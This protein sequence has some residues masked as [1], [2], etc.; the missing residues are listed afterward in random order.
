[1]T[2]RAVPSLRECLWVS[3]VVCLFSCVYAPVLSAQSSPQTSLATPQAPSQSLAFAFSTISPSFVSPSVVS[4]IVAAPAVSSTSRSK[5]MVAVEQRFVL[6]DGLS[7]TRATA[8]E[9]APRKKR[10]RLS[11]G[12]AAQRPTGIGVGLGFGPSGSTFSGGTFQSGAIQSGVSGSFGQIRGD[13]G[14]RFAAAD[15]QASALVGDASAGSRVDLDLQWDV[16]RRWT[17]KATA[18]GAVALPDS[19]Q[20]TAS[21][22][23]SSFAAPAD[24]ERSSRAPALGSALDLELAGRLSGFDVRASFSDVS[25]QYRDPTL[26]RQRATGQQSQLQVRRKAQF[27]RVDALVQSGRTTTKRGRAQPE[28]IVT[29]VNT[30]LRLPLEIDTEVGY[31]ELRT[32]GRRESE[33]RLGLGRQFGK[34]RLGWRVRH[35]EKEPASAAPVNQQAERGLELRY[36]PNPSLVVTGGSKE[37]THTA[38]PSDRSLRSLYF[39]PVWKLADDA[40]VVKL[41]FDWSVEGRSGPGRGSTATSEI[42][43]QSARGTLVWKGLSASDS[44]G[45]VAPDMPSL[46]ERLGARLDLKVDVTY[47]SAESRL[48]GNGSVGAS[49]AAPGSRTQRDDVSG[50]VGVVIRLR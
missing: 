38:G 2:V 44:E 39:K 8:P 25:S 50:R 30:G 21:P 33:A 24:R 1:M 37:Q 5:T 45:A 31:R 19:T 6:V 20:G 10:L 23:S 42:E 43:K 48:A 16:S 35:L 17:A 11:L 13:G 3:L 47:L 22:L 4:P 41:S 34:L 29:R 49:G 27:W 12:T 18:R 32:A 46:A 7:N 26:S 40:L 15:R 9:A 36:R 14:P 28:R